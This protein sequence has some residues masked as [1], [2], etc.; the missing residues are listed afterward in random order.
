MDFDWE[1]EDWYLRALFKI[2]EI[3][4]FEVEGIVDRFVKA[5]EDYCERPN[6]PGLRLEGLAGTCFSTL[7]QTTKEGASDA[8]A[9]CAII[10]ARKD[11]AFFDSTNSS[12]DVTPSYSPLSIQA[13]AASST[14]DL[15]LLSDSGI[16]RNEE[17]EDK[18][19]EILRIFVPRRKPPPP[20]DVESYELGW[21]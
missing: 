18:A 16:D 10:A 7:M 14:T 4:D 1:W 8:A 11:S 20:I 2:A 12:Q 19:K 15:T 17:T 21:M 5:F 13:T 3:F 9:T 6:G